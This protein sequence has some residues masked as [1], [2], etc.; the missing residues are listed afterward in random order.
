[1]VR[2]T[3]CKQSCLF[4]GKV[5]SPY[6]HQKFGLYGQFWGSPRLGP[7]DLVLGPS[8]SLTLGKRKEFFKGP[9][10]IR[11][12]HHDYKPDLVPIILISP[13]LPIFSTKFP[14]SIILSHYL[15]S[16]PHLL[17]LDDLD[18]DT[19]EQTCRFTSL[20]LRPLTRFLPS[21]FNNPSSLP[22]PP[23]FPIKTC[24]TRYSDPSI[25]KPL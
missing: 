5:I 18:K 13:L 14:P 10:R 20:P 22:H 11:R 8:Y 25:P 16:I 17:S 1:M 2:S 19:K 24:P 4:P 9:L 3:I 6:S 21:T 7:G 15:A 23:P 12:F